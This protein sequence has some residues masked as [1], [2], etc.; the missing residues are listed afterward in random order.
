MKNESEFSTCVCNIIKRAEG[1]VSRVESKNTSPGIPDLDY[2]LQGN[3]GKIELKYCTTKRGADIK[4]SQVRWM[5]QRV[6]SGGKPIY[7]CYNSDKKTVH[8]VLDVTNPA[9]HGTVRWHVWEELSKWS[10]HIKDLD[11]FLV[12]FILDGQYD[13]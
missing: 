8:F 2:C 7:L 4:P 11:N 1:D 9:L 10:I 5:R 3:E 6:K 12:S 13:K